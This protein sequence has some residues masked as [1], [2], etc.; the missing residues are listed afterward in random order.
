MGSNRRRLTPVDPLKQWAARLVRDAVPDGGDLDAM[1]LVGSVAER[2][3]ETL[4]AETA[5]VAA[6]PA[7]LELNGADEPPGGWANPWLPGL[8]HEQAVS[9][10]VRR[11]R[12]AWYTPPDLVRGLVRLVDQVTTIPPFA[13]DP[14]CGG[15]AFLLAVLDHWVDRGVA[16]SEALT[17]IGGFD[18]DPDAVTVCRLSIELWAA[19][20]GVAVDEAPLADTVRIADALTVEY[21]AR[22]PEH[23]LVIG[24]PPFATPL[25]TAKG[26]SLPEQAECYRSAH[27]EE[28]GQYA[29]LAAIHLH[30]AVDTVAAGCPVM[31]IMP[32][33]ILSSRDVAGLRARIARESTTLA[34]WAAREAV[35]DAGVRA[36]APV[37]KVAVGSTGPV[38][39]ATG[40]RAEI[41]GHLPPTARAADA[42][43]ATAARS[44]GAPT[45]PST[46]LRPTA[47]VGALC[48]ATAGFRDE[49][50]GLAEAAAEWVGPGSPPNRLVTVGSVD[51]LSTRWATGTTRLGGRRWTAPYVR[52]GHLDDKVR[53]WVDRQAV[54]KLVVATQSKLIEPVLDPV[55]DLVPSTPL[56]SVH[57]DVDDLAHVAAVLLAPPVVAWAWQQWFGSALAVD[58]LKMAANQIVELPLPADRAVWDTAAEVIT[59]TM[60]DNPSGVSVED[61]WA[62][63]V[64]VAALMNTAFRASADV[65][66]WWLARVPNGNAPVS[67]KRHR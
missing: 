58:A 54:P 66:D 61:G 30:H 65:F 8:V 1:A 2:A 19:A 67:P 40:P 12:G 5:S 51:P 21:P 46:V 41:I 36:C 43:A 53:R 42:W 23:R 31:L 48:T 47:T 37:V 15:G 13:F 52:L 9:A 25:K 60:A 33:S 57:A 4:T 27:H 39:L 64:E 56:L 62:A 50:Y 55:G 34:M 35:F 7:P 17:R 32:Q 38:T 49:Y 29:D 11:N 6:L 20:H 44:L 28:L 10:S 26:G 18:I 14:T 63:A 59:T 3:V 24:N 45:L 22:W 16:P